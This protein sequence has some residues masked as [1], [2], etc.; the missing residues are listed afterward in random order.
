MIWPYSGGV[1]RPVIELKVLHK[2]RAQV[3]REGITQAQSYAGRCGADEDH[4]VVFDR[5]PGKAWSGKIFR[6]K[7]V[8]KTSEGR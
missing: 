4:Q 2:S 3:I 7:E 5:T 1:Q 8:Y 6:K